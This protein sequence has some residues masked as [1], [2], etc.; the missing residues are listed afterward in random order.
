[1][2]TDQIK[3]NDFP[4][5]V[6]TTTVNFT[7]RNNLSQTTPSIVG[8]MK[9]T[10]TE[11]QFEGVSGGGSSY[12]T[13]MTT[14]QMDSRT[15]NSF[16]S[17]TFNDITETAI[18]DATI[19]SSRKDIM[20]GQE[21]VSGTNAVME[22][23]LDVT[24]VNYTNHMYTSVSCT[25]TTPNANPSAW[26][27]QDTIWIQSDVESKQLLQLGYEPA[28]LDL[29]SFSLNSLDENV[30]ATGTSGP[31]QHHYAAMLAPLIPEG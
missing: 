3:Y 11:S 5:V 24:F 6:T 23:S 1:M 17:W 14:N 29:Y 22:N 9:D 8:T 31:Y 15:W 4:K 19:L 7:L 25:D 13:K 28:T 18:D 16:V 20:S 27:E 10:N 26:S 12:Q 2:T 21:V 30:L